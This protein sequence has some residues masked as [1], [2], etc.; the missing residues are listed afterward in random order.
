MKSAGNVLLARMPPTLPAATKT[1]SGLACAMKRS[2]SSE[3]RKSR[4]RR[5][6]V[7]MSQSSRS[8]RRTMAEPTMPAW[9]V[10]KTRLPFRSN[11]TGEPLMLC[12]LIVNVAPHSFAA[13]F[14]EIRHRPFLAPIGRTKLYDAS[15]VFAVLCSGRQEACRS[16]SG[17][18]SAGRFRSARGRRAHRCLV[19]A[20]SLPRHSIF[21]PTQAN[22]F[23]TNSRTECSSPVAKI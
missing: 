14:F 2:T 12:L 6:A 5:A 21:L 23:S 9:P 4:S 7:T 16:R 18:N 15:R 20:I 11:M 3:R 10:T 8:S 22:A 13:R 1:A 17:E 19:S